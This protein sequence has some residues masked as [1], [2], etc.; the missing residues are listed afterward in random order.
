[1]TAY[2]VLVRHLHQARGV[3]VFCFIPALMEPVPLRA[4][5]TFHD[6][7]RTFDRGHSSFKIKE[8]SYEI[9]RREVLAS[10]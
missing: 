10:D 3:T 2:S 7:E 8:S 4:S 1:M 9:S 6:L 5:S